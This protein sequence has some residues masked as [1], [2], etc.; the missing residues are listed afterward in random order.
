M[1][2]QITCIKK[3]NGN[4]ENP[5]VA[6]SELGWINN[7]TGET[8]RATRLQ[9]YDFVLNSANLAFV[10]DRNGN[11]ARVIPAKTTLGTKYVKTVADRT[12]TD[13]LLSLP[14]CNL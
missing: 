13:N 1:A 10:R 3:D 12:T 11:N 8:G 2:V 6:I 5:Y 14:E 7:S 4:H 9:M